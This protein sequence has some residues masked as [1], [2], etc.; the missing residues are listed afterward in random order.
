M[1]WFAIIGLLHFL[2]CSCKISY[3]PKCPFY[4]FIAVALYYV[5]EVLFLLIHISVEGV[6][7]VTTSGKLKGRN[8]FIQIIKSPPL[9][10]VKISSEK[11]EI[12]ESSLLSFCKHPI[13][14]SGCDFNKKVAAHNLTQSLA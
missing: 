7:S 5:I 9:K 11:F 12:I 13:A 4:I 10:A 6:A 1:A 3:K 14:I 2:R 8:Y